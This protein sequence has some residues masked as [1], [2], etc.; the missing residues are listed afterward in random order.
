MRVGALGAGNDDCVAHLEVCYRDRRQP[1][2]HVVDIETTTAT[3]WTT[4]GCTASLSCRGAL[5]SS[6]TT[7]TTRTHHH[8]SAAHFT[9]WWE[10][11][12]HSILLDHDRQRLLSLHVVDL[13]LSRSGINC[14]N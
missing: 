12:Q 7:C 2:E 11:P 4:S 10:L 14:S 8:S 13:D 9:H 6:L 3:H 5:T 1:F